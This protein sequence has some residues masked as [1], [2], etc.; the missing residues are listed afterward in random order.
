M[1]RPS[2]AHRFSTFLAC[3]LLAC[4]LAGLIA[5]VPAG[6]HVGTL[7]KTR[8]PLGQQWVTVGHFAFTEDQLIAYRA[9]RIANGTAPVV[10][11]P[12]AKTCGIID[13]WYWAN[14]M[15][16]DPAVGSMLR[17]TTS[18]GSTRL[19][20]VRWP[21]SFLLDTD[22]NRNGIADHHDQYRFREGLG[23]DYLEC[24][25]T[26]TSTS[27][28]ANSLKAWPKHGRRR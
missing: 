4:L 12:T 21:A 18:S 25:T 6:A 27:L 5:T 17:A 19:P 26:T 9:R 11:C 14:E 3:P 23:G 22:L 2:A 28:P 15:A 20:L 1:F 13:E 10:I 24:R 16:H 7:Y 8:C